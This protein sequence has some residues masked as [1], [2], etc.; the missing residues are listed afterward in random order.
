MPG[1][2]APCQWEQGWREASP[3]RSS[4]SSGLCSTVQGERGGDV[5]S[6]SSA[7]GD[8]KGGGGAQEGFWSLEASERASKGIRRNRE[9]RASES[10]GFQGPREGP[11]SKDARRVKPL[12]ERTCRLVPRLKGGEAPRSR[13]R[14]EMPS[15]ASEE[16]GWWGHNQ[17][18]L[19]ATH[20]PAGRFLRHLSGSH[21]N[22]RPLTWRSRCRRRR[23][24]GPSW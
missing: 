8:G 14:R 5:P 22:T 3:A 1:T 13:L 18:G 17:D 7:L 20:H 19:S 15:E 2:G 10:R 11:K 21:R 9:R 24:P 6:P 4:L 12:Q 16:Q 23:C